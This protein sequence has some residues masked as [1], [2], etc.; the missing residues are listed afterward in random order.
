MHA[1][2]FRLTNKPDKQKT[3]PDALRQ[4]ALD[5]GNTFKTKHVRGDTPVQ[6]ERL[7][8]M[9]RALAEGPVPLNTTT[10]KLSQAG[11]ST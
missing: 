5:G 3:L 9:S 4:Q 7:G 1:H 10:W 8:T 6:M 11:T 2:L